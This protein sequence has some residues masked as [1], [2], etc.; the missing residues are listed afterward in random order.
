MN[1]QLA[2]IQV[3]RRIPAQVGPTL[4]ELVTALSQ[5]TDS[6]EEAVA[7]VMELVAEGRLRLEG[8]F[9]ECHLS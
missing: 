5:V 6:A 2:R 7:R 1:A 8:N 4:L 9:R 3:S